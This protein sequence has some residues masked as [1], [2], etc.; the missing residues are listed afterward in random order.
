MDTAEP[1]ISQLQRW[2][3]RLHRFPE[4]GFNEARTADF[5]AQVL[6]AGPDCHARWRALNED[7]FVI[8]ITGRGGHAARPQMAIDPLV[9]GAET[10][11]A[12]QTLVARSSSRN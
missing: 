4:T 2:R 10:V 6:A 3:H 7:N 8:R 5:V 12:R 11:L 1:D 9:I